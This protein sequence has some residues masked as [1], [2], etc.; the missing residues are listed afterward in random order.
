MRKA[1]CLIWDDTQGGIGMLGTIMQI[2]TRRSPVGIP[3]LFCPVEEGSNPGGDRDPPNVPNPG[4][5]TPRVLGRQL[6]PLPPQ[7]ASGRQLVVKGMSPRSQRAP[8][9]PNGVM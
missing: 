9:A 1:I 2:K 3:H 4:G 6:P 5:A 8:K 7:G